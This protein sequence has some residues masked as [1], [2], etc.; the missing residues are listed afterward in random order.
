MSDVKYMPIDGWPG[1]RVGDD[2]TV[3]SCKQRNWGHAP[4]GWHKLRP[5]P[6]AQGYLFVSLYGGTRN[7][8]TLRKVH[9]LVLEAFVRPRMPGEQVLHFPNPE[10][11]DNR[12]CNLRWGTA[13]QN[14]DD[15]DFHGTTSR[16]MRHYACRLTDE[17]I[18]KIR[19]EYI[20]GSSARGARPLGR[21]YG[22]SET[23]IRNIIANKKRRMPQGPV[24]RPLPYTPPT[25]EECSR[26]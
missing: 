24:D 5:V 12:L 26:G 11:T 21:K 13:K 22:V 9:Q 6:N 18:A 15:R 4:T 1:Y 16:G 17:Q 23:H 8:K 25:A 7:R 10:I 19:L 14:A 3:W 20:A 2:G